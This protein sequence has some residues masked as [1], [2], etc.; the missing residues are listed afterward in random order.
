MVAPR[1]QWLHVVG[2]EG[3]LS[4]TGALNEEVRS[5]CRVARRLATGCPPMGKI[6]LKEGLCYG[7]SGQSQG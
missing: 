4:F 1:F 6:A 7:A 2:M 3:T 5:Q